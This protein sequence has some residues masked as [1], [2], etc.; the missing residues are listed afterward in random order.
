MGREI[1]NEEEHEI[2]VTSED[3]RIFWKRV[4]EWTTSSPSS[5]H[6]GHYKASVE[7]ILS[8]K[9]HAQQLTVIARS[10]DAPE[11]W[12]VSLQGS[13]IFLPQGKFVLLFLV[14]HCDIR[15]D[16]VANPRFFVPSPL[17]TGLSLGCTPHLMFSNSGVNSELIQTRVQTFYQIFWSRGYFLF[18]ANRTKKCSVHLFS[19]VFYTL[20]VQKWI[21]RVMVV[22]SSIIC[23]FQSPSKIQTATTNVHVLYCTLEYLPAFVQETVR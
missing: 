14:L 3:F 11:R 1:R 21:F 19:T 16:N 9:I 5:I 17:V 4:S 6:Y 12:G 10:G 8:S 20:Y 13:A 15:V 22:Y 23:L 7:N 2:V 18:V